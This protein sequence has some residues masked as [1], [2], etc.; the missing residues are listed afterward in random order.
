MIK[1]KLENL[2]AGHAYWADKKAELKALSLAEFHSCTSDT[3]NGD[4]CYEKAYQ[5]L[6][7]EMHEDPRTSPHFEDSFDAIE[8]CEHC[9]KHRDLKRKAAI[10]SRRLG[11]IRSAMTRVGRKLEYTDKTTYFGEDY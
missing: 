11:Q 8:P 4:H 9:I 1:S 3:F 10:A 7:E 2:I 5:D 6:K